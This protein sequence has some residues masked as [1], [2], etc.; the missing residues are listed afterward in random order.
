MT[1]RAL[2]MRRPRREGE[3][4]DLRFA[5]CGMMA[6]EVTDSTVEVT[7]RLCRRALAVA[8][9]LPPVE[10]EVLGVELP[11]VRGAHEL[12]PGQVAIVERSL[13][14]GTDETPRSR[15]R[16]WGAL[17]RQHARVIDDGSPVRSSSDPARFGARVQ[18]SGGAVRM[19]SG[20]DDMIE[21][22]VA[23]ER[24]TVGVL[25]VGPHRLTGMQQRAVYLARCEGRPLVGRIAPDRK[26]LVTTRVPL[27]AAQVAE[28]LGGDWTPHH[29]GLV[30][31]A[32]RAKMA[33]I[34]VSKGILPE[35]ASGPEERETMKI[36]GFD[37]YGWKEIAEFMGT[38]DA[39]ARRKRNEGLPVRTID[40]SGRVIAS[41]A[42]IAAW[43]RA[44]VR[45]S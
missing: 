20:R 43:L 40:S 32:V 26:G 11:A 36:P 17:Y 27:S 21:V 30:V 12:T 34:L 1:A 6:V 2:H 35:R 19:P 38:D 5:V 10:P 15:F 4:L 9:T 3:G 29:V 45:A 39:T 22:D 14:V 18:S 37:L 24:A 7:C 33:P 16:S 23:L 42:E 41:R 28:R 13:A 31:R 25:V 44:Q 8:P